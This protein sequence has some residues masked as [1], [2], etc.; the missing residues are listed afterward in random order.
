MD[1]FM[2]QFE[3]ECFFTFESF[4]KKY[5]FKDWEYF[6]FQKYFEYKVIEM[7]KLM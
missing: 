1:K 6:D 4:Q 3:H 5:E 2:K 7:N